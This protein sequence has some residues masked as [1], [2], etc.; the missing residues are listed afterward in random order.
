M[1]VTVDKS[2]EHDLA[3]GADHRDVG[4]A[5]GELGKGADFGND[6]VALQNRT[7]VNLGQ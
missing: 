6:A 2:R 1:M 5:R 4:M 7:V 3:P